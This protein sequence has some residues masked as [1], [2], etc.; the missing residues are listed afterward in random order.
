MVMYQ[1]YEQIALKRVILTRAI[2]SDLHSLLVIASLR[3]FQFPF[4]S[5]IR[6]LRRSLAI[7]RVSRL[8]H[9]RCEQLV[10]QSSAIISTEGTRDYL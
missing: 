8:E 7:D 6:A 5:D 9:K 4:M 3:F 1:V 2:E 10:A